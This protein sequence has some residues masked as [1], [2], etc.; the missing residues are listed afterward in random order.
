V[1]GVLGYHLDQQKPPWEKGE[2][3][4]QVHDSYVERFGPEAATVGPPEA[5]ADSL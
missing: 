2:R 1:S 5:I 3:W 4:G